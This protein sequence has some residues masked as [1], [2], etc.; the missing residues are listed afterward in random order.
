MLGGLAI[1]GGPA[2][3]NI[4]TAQSM[5]FGLARLF[6]PDAQFLLAAAIFGVTPNLLIKGLQQKAQE[7]ES[8]LRVAKRQRRK[9]EVANLEVKEV[10]F[11][12]L[13]PFTVEPSQLTAR[14]RLLPMPPGWVWLAQRPS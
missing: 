6:S 1:L 14:A 12:T 10:T 5:T 7:Y 11:E 3:F 9:R 8:E 4:N 2:L 13:F